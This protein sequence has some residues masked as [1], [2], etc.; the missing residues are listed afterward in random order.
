MIQSLAQERPELEAQKRGRGV[1]RFV[2]VLVGTLI[3][4]LNEWN[5]LELA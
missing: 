4:E 2:A 1:K 3:N 5:E